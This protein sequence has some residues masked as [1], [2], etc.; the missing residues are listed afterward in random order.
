MSDFVWKPRLSIAITQF[1]FSIFNSY[2]CISMFYI[3]WKREKKNIVVPWSISSM[4]KNSCRWEKLKRGLTLQ[5]GLKAKRY[6][7][8][9]YPRNTQFSPKKMSLFSRG[10]TTLE[11]AASV[12]RLVCRSVRPSVTKTKFERFFLSHHS[13]PAHPSTTG[14]GYSPLRPCFTNEDEGEKKRK[15]TKKICW[16]SYSL[17]VKFCR[18]AKSIFWV[19]YHDSKCGVEK[20][21]E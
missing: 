18:K 3:G 9:V 20:R 19:L 5:R 8:T 11:L 16:E 17:N 6:T 13:A 4:N 2:T 21:G 7:A 15:D 10:H 14:G 1:P 12:R